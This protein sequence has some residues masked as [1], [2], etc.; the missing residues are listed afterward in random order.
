MAKKKFAGYATYNFVDKDPVIDELRT[1][2]SDEKASYADIHATSGVSVNTLYNWFNGGT[3]RP[4]HATIMAVA[5][6][7]GYDYKLVKT[8]KSFRKAA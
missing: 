3:R 8:G 7:L 6:A 2:V 1:I 4:Q 5:R